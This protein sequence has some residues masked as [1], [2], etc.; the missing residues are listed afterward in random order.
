MAALD[1]VSAAL[2]TSTLITLNKAV[3]ID[4]QTSAEVAAKFVADQG[5]TA[6]KKGTGKLTVGAANF[7]ENITIAEIYGAVL[8]DAGYDVTVRP[9]GNRETYMPALESGEVNVVPEYAATAAE[10]L[11]HKLNGDE[12]RRP[13]PPETSRRRPR[14]SPTSAR[15]WASCSARPPRHRTRTPSP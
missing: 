6:P 2:D 7:S 14:R 9:I 8:R 11:N 1:V 4:R 15:R 3:D 5:L 10:F 13:W 12:R